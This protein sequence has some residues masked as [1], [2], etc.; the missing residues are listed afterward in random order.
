MQH[1][2]LVSVAALVKNDCGQILLVNSPWRGWEYPGGLIEPGETFETALRR[3]IREETGVEV[4][5]ERFVGICKNVEK[6]IVNIDF[7]CRYVSGELT[8]SEE[9]TEVVWVTPEQAFEMITFP[10]TKKRLQNMLS[11]DKDAH[12]FGFI[13]E[14]FT[15][16]ED[17]QF[18]VGEQA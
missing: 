8:V 9:S 11:G 10:L 7:I 18:P 16:V 5:I 2:H 3:E 15:V 4:E 13:R 12:F 14:P 1:N 6:D 17:I